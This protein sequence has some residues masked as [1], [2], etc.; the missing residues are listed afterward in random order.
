MS[1]TISHYELQEELGHG[2]MGRVYKSYDTSLNRTIVLKLLAPELTL[3]E[4]SRRR[5]L[6]E[7]RLASSLDHPNICT[8]YE[9]HEAQGVYYIAMQYVEGTTL[10]R[11]I[12]GR[13]LANPAL[14][15]IAL[16]VADAVARAHDR[17]IIHR[18]IKP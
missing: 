14:L 4:E 17:G 18:D 1:R 2:G 3:E 12:N 13:P 5:F 9:I 8:I 6:R 16:Q 10:K 15:S 7:A 11:T